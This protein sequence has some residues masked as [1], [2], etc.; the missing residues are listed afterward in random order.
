MHG[1]I[2]LKHNI[3]TSIKLQSII[4]FQRAYKV[5]NHEQTSLYNVE[6]K[7]KTLLQ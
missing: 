2:E 3:T 1:I 5:H 4:T 6:N 7:I